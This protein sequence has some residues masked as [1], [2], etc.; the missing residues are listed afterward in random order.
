MKTPNLTDF[1]LNAIPESYSLRP[2]NMLEILKQ[3]GVT[4]ITQPLMFV[5]DGVYRWGFTRGAKSQKNLKNKN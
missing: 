5:I 2:Y 3:A 1:S 4:E